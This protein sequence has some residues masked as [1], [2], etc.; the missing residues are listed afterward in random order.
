MPSTDAHAA[1]PAE[2][3]IDPPGRWTGLE[4]RELWAHRELIYF[5]TKRELQVRYKQSF[6]GV[7]WAVLQPLTFAF[8]FALFFGQLAPL[9]TEG[10]PYAVFA[11]VALVPWQFASQ[12]M[13]NGANSLV[14]DADLISKVYFPRLALPLSKGLSL[15]LDLVIAMGVVLL[16]MWAYGV[17]IASEV[18]LVPFFLLLVLVASFAVATLLAAVNVKYRDI[19]VIVP[20]VVQIGF[21]ISPILYSGNDLVPEEWRTVWAINPMVG[22]IG[23]LRWSL[24]GA[25]Y[26]GTLEIAISCASALVILVVAL[27]YFRRTERFFADVI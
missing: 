2:L 1:D 11:I 3:V 24:I 23:G 20:T 9:P 6:F 27:W 21:F 25:S 15:L 18:Y 7:S 17:G 5:L 22:A 10:F 4:L 14:Q 8:I 12:S 13:T 16:V 19:A 26:P